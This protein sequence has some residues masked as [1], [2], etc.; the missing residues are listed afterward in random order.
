MCVEEK[1]QEKSNSNKYDKK[2]KH[3]GGEKMC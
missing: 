3:V 1:N 2:V